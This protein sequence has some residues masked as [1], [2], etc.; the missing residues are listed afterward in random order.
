MLHLDALYCIRG[1]VVQLE[2]IQVFLRVVDAGGISRAADQ[3]NIAKSA[4]S[5]R[6]AD[7]ESRLKVKL[8]QRTTR[9]FHLT[10]EGERYYN[11]A[12][13]L[14]IYMDELEG[15]V[16]QD[17]GALKGRLSI[18]I[19]LSFGLLH[20]YKAIEAFKN[21]YPDIDLN[22]DLSD[23]EV[24]MVEEGID[25]AFRIGEKLDDS[26]IQA[27]KIFPLDT[28]LAASPEYIKEHGPFETVDDLKHAEFL[29]YSVVSNV[30]TIEDPNG[31]VHSISRK[32]RLQSNNGDFLLKLAI[33]GHGLVTQPR[34]ICWQ[35]LKEKKLVPLLQDHKFKALYSYAV[36]PQ[37]RYLSKNARAFIDFL[38]AF[39]QDN[40]EWEA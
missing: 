7:L 30:M 5:R 22:I 38:V 25:I 4:V 20:M 1:V 15:S 9:R 40:R 33:A 13:D 3:L 6:L 2:D 27:R 39:Y 26:L 19:P 21:L 31:R 35:A 12:K 16:K 23:R 14:V 11:K 24:N 10:E 32:S 17:D 34:F 8:I 28:L 29:R 37:N 18:S 36:Y